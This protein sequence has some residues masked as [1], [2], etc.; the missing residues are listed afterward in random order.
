M[1]GSAAVDDPGPP[2]AT[3]D[4]ESVR[5]RTPPIPAL[6]SSSSIESVPSPPRTTA[7][8]DTLRSSAPSPDPTAVHIQAQN[9][10]PVNDEESALPREGTP[11]RVTSAAEEGQHSPTSSSSSQVASSSSPSA[12]SQHPTIRRVKLYRLQDDAWIDLGTGHCAVQLV[13]TPAQQP[14]VNSSPESATKSS[15]ADK[16]DNGA[17]IIVKREVPAKE[18]EGGDPSSEGDLEGGDV[19]LRS[20]V[21][22]Y[23]PG[24]LSDEDDFDLDDDQDAAAAGKVYDLGGYQRQQDTLIVWTEP[25]GEEMALSFATPSGCAD[26]WDFIRTARKWARECRSRHGSWVPALTFACHAQTEDQTVTSPSP[27]PSLSSPQPFPHYNLASA[28]PNRLPDPTLGNIAEVEQ[29]I[30]NMAR[31][32][33][34]RERTASMIV[35]TQIVQKLIKVHEEAEDLESLEDLHALCRVMQMICEC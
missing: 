20:K 15:P 13:E 12:Q 7:V 1:D 14:T 18:S 17:W 8:Q 26:I 29:S 22:P 30:R 10:E 25:T 23:P 6:A 9:V 5:Q 28:A 35:K 31:T 33:V 32:A 4:A 3:T 34:G 24:Y 19:I 21:M 16:A 2:A 27:S 11:E